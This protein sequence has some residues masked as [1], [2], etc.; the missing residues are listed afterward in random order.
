MQARLSVYAATDPTKLDD[1]QMRILK[2]LPTLEAVQKELGEVKKTIEVKRLVDLTGAFSNLL[3]RCTRPISRMTWRPGASK[4]RRRMTRVYKLLL[5]PL[6]FVLQFTSSSSNT[7]LTTQQ[8]N[9]LSK[10]SRL[11]SFAGLR[12]SLE[13]PSFDGSAFF[14][15]DLERSAIISI[16][17]ALLGEDSERKQI[18]IN[19][20]L[21]G[22]GEFDGVPCGCI[23]YSSSAPH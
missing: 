13:T 5:N 4:S 19:G 7:R 1:D 14:A 10:T 15:D 9:L 6:K 20:F 18:A 17:D 3:V 22:T 12:A 2:T 16:I 11:L 23:F 21:L 8:T